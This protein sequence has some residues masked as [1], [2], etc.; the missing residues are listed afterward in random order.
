MAKRVTQEL[1]ASIE[2]VVSDV[3]GVWTDGRLTIGDD[4]REFKTFHVRDG[5]AVAMG[6]ES[7]I[8]FAILS[9]RTSKAVDRRARELKIG[10]VVQ[11]SRDKGIDFLQLCSDAGVSAEKT[12]MI[13][14]D[15]P[16]LSAFYH[17]GL[18]V[19]P[20]DAATEVL[21]AADVTLAVRGGEGVIREFVEKLLEARGDLTRRGSLRRKK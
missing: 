21:D 11:G 7:G 8:G 17:A 4:G 14:D 18:S 3:D 10:F 5:H 19:A 20:A 9:G 15:L 1:L 12:A 2:L 16:D 6:R 13:G